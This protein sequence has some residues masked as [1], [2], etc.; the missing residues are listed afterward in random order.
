MTHHAHT[1]KMAVKFSKMKDRMIFNIATE[2]P[3]KL[4]QL[5]NACNYIM[6]ASE[7]IQAL[8]L[9][10]A[11]DLMQVTRVSCITQVELIIVHWQGDQLPQKRQWSIPGESPRTTF[12]PLR[13][14]CVLP[15]TTTESVC[16]NRYIKQQLVYICIQ[17]QPTARLPKEP[18]KVGIPK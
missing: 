1:Q 8:E 11:S 6:L 14:F 3:W 2:N 5:H 7:E 16:A 9:M 18:N 12:E 17:H 4:T 10:E 15:Q 13:L